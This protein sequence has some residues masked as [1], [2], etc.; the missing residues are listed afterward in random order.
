MADKERG[1]VTL[2]IGDEADGLGGT[3]GAMGTTG[4][5]DNSYTSVTALSE[6]LKEDD[7]STLTPTDLSPNSTLVQTHDTSKG[8]MAEQETTETNNPADSRSRPQ[9]A[10]RQ[11]PTSSTTKPQVV[12]SHVKNPVDTQSRKLAV[13]SNT[14]NVPV[15]LHDKAKDIRSE[16]TTGLRVTRH[17]DKPVVQPSVHDNAPFSKEDIRAIVRTEIEPIIQVCS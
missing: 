7:L 1:V 6:T 15:A 14:I 9:S 11:P 13:T 2:H 3:P 10:P 5:A 16:D 4:C 17:N 12:Q 8:S